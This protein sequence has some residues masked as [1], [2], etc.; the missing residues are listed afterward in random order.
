MSASPC[1][2]L[3]VSYKGKAIEETLGQRI[4]RLR[5]AQDVTMEAFARQVGV[6]YVSVSEWE[7][8]QA[9]PNLESLYKIADALGITV[10]E[11]VDKNG[12]EAA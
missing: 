8:G 9:T 1:K 7:R 6:S 3:V 11:L 5:K 2:L 10:G 4:R 12:S